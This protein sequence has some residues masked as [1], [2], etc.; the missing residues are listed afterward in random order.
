MMAD[1][2]QSPGLSATAWNTAGVEMLKMASGRPFVMVPGTEIRVVCPGSRDSLPV[3]QEWRDSRNQIWRRLEL[4]GSVAAGPAEG[5]SESMEIR[6]QD[7]RA[8]ER[9]LNAS[10]AGQIPRLPRTQISDNEVDATETLPDCWVAAAQG[11]D[12]MIDSHIDLMSTVCEKGRLPGGRDASTFA[13]GDVV[14]T[15]TAI[16]AE[17]WQ[18]A[19]DS[20]NPRMSL[21]VK[22]ARE[23]GS[24]L[25]SVCRNPRRVLRRERQLQRLDR[26]REVDGGCLRW[27]A[28][29][30]GFTVAEKAGTRQECLAIARVESIDTLENRVVRDCLVRASRACQKYL[31]EHRLARSHARIE[32]VSRFRTLITQLWKN[33]AIS[34]VSPLNAVPD[35]NYVLQMDS[36]Y[37]LIWSAY[38]MLVR[39]Q[40]LEDNVWRWRHRLFSEHVQL[41]IIAALQSLCVREA[42]H[43]GD[44]IIRSEQHAGQF[45]DSRTELGPWRLRDAAGVS[46][47]LV[48]GDQ[49]ALHPM[50]PE[51]VSAM[52]PDVVLVARVRKQLRRMVCIWTMLDFGLSQPL[53]DEQISTFRGGKNR[54]ENGSDVRSMLVLPSLSRNHMK[55]CDRQLTEADSESGPSL[56]CLSEASRCMRIALPIQRDF[57]FLLEQLAWALSL[58]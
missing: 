32:S 1:A 19:G 34:E 48:R 27:L 23:L 28:R 43:G 30:P 4:P 38:Q 10:V 56:K 17:E 20:A 15:R 5:V 12:A 55:S 3:A 49:L 24:V 50:V 8:I 47:D 40:M 18:L 11:V 22:L 54:D 25:Q 57:A 6:L 36:R 45:I 42:T 9:V 37:S 53:A 44:V 33:T 13:A 26:V 2:D 29:Q 58:T 14:I 51:H 41:G 35:A 21:I 39:Q 16:L 31:R 7:S 46:V 52:G